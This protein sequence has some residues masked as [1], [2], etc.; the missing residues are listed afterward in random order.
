MHVA[1]LQILGYLSI[2]NEKYL[3]VL[4]EAPSKPRYSRVILRFLEG[5]R[6]EMSS[7]KVCISFFLWLDVWMVSW[8]SLFKHL[9]YCTM[10]CQKTEPCSWSS[11]WK[12][13]TEPAALQISFS[14]LKHYNFFQW[15]YQLHRQL[16]RILAV[17]RR[18]D[19]QN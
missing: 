11:S 9:N 5:S 7:S 16:L 13:G 17:R 8:S 6:K 4:G 12:I 10:P 19:N 3:L 15:S 18:F 2:F 14:Q 1:S